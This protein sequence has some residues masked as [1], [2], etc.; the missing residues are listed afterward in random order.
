MIV[1]WEK[2]K[3]NGGKCKK[4]GANLRHEYTY[5]DGG[6]KWKCIWCGNSIIINMINENKFIEK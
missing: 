5:D 6:R 3:F 2:N 4:C 1:Y